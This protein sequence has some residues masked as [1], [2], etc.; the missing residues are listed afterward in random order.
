MA[1][2]TQTNNAIHLDRVRDV[3][4]SCLSS[5][6][7]GVSQRSKDQ[8]EIAESPGGKRGL[9]GRGQKLLTCSE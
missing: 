9:E 1:A 7:A 5:L 6:R 3:S 8:E 2:M 4:G